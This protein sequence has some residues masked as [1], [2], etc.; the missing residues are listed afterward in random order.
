MFL[1]ENAGPAENTEYI[2]FDY[3]LRSESIHFIKNNP[4]LRHDAY[5]EL[6]P[7]M[8]RGRSAQSPKQL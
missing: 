3:Y 7:R 6:G 1:C 8:N 5:P 4:E 2:T